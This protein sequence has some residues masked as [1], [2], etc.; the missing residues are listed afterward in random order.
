MAAVKTKRYIKNP[1]YVDAVRITRDNFN[2]V[3]KW[4]R[5][6]IQTE[7]PD[8]PQNPGAKYIKIQAHNPINTRQT[9]AYV[10]D[11]VL[12]TD[13]GFKVYSHKAFGESFQEVRTDHSVEAQVADFDEQIDSCVP[14]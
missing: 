7:G 11:W 2:D 14:Q 8:H 3:S 1:L 6:H 5:G 9:K 12:Q 13:R 4:C 10:G